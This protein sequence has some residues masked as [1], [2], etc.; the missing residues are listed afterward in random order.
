MI[1]LSTVACPFVDGLAGGAAL[2]SGVKSVRASLYVGSSGAA[3]TGAL[4]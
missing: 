1:I 4:T 3:H 2:Q